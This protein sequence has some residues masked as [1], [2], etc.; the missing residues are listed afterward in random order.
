MNEESLFAAASALPAGPERDSLL[1]RECAGDPTL[2]GRLKLL[3]DAQD[4]HAGI[5]DRDGSSER[6]ARGLTP[7]LTQLDE[8]ELLEEI[9]RGG[10]GVVYRARHRSLHKLVAVK[11]LLGAVLDNG[12]K[13]RIRV[14][15][16]ALGRL[17]HPNLLQ[18][19]DAREIDGQ[20]LIVT[21]LV[22]G[23]SLDKLLERTRRF[24]V[25]TACD[26]IRQAACGLAAAHEQN[27]IHR[28]IKPAN[29]M[30]EQ[31]TETV[32]LLDF[33]LALLVRPDCV[34][35][36][37]PTLPGQALG[38]P[39]FMP[40]EQ[41]RDSHLVSEK[42]DIYALGIT[43]YCLLTGKPPFERPTLIELMH[44]HCFAPR[45]QIPGL[46]PQL[47]QLLLAMLHVDPAQRPSA[48]DV[49]RAVDRYCVGPVPSLL[50][51]LID[52]LEKHGIAGRIGPEIERVKRY[53]QRLPRH[54]VVNVF[55]EAGVYLGRKGLVDGPER[56][57]T[58]L[59]QI[60]LETGDDNEAFELGIAVL[61]E[62][63]ECFDALHLTAVAA[64]QT[65]FSYGGDP[66]ARLREAV[67]LE[68]A[69]QQ[70]PSASHHPNLGPS[71]SVLAQTYHNLAKHY[72]S[73][74]DD[75]S[76]GTALQQALECF[77]RRLTLKETALGLALYA[78]A[79]VDA[80]ELKPARDTAA[81]ACE[82]DWFL[83]EAQQL[84]LQLAEQRFEPLDPTEEHFRRWSLVAGEWPGSPMHRTYLMG[85][86]AYLQKSRLWPEMIAWEAESPA[87][88]DAALQSEVARAGCGTVERTLHFEP[89]T[90]QA[91]GR[92]RQLVYHAMIWRFD[93]SKSCVVAGL[94]SIRVFGVGNNQESAISDLE[95]LLFMVQERVVKSRQPQTPLIVTLK[96]W[97]SERIN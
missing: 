22:D 81:R 80:G 60:F 7:Q 79:L 47:N 16:A 36:H 4:V 55:R 24:P 43:L 13:Q 83:R 93:E 1:D 28:D 85:Y 57:L 8:Y 88:W 64:R 65:A 73:R 3:L 68:L 31:S 62:A 92:P 37:G 2:R 39:H 11:V 26:Y 86:R 58:A 61:K 12:A 75:R 34:A 90:S 54:R 87:A 48:Q 15:M 56:G 91:G 82:L 18:A 44:A 35:L 25:A 78:E 29:M 59:I 67:R 89:G 51:P 27:L 72:R 76:A 41:W 49:V 45:P 6:T 40:P 23:V 32:K 94:P 14:E 10:M 33:G 17:K 38:T 97:F 77:R 53:L 20:P 5:L 42:S 74:G 19:F 71:L 50:P 70:T 46:D 21:E 52:T 69:A 96:S 84:L 63:P 30:L 9:G 95:S 66:E